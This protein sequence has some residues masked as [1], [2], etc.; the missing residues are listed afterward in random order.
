MK[1]QIGG[2]ARTHPTGIGFDAVPSKGF[3]HSGDARIHRG[4]RK[5]ASD[6]GDYFASPFNEVFGQQI[7]ACHIV[8]THEIEV[9]PA[10]IGEQV[11]VK[12]DNGYAGVTKRLGQLAVCFTLPGSQFHRGKEDAADFAR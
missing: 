1:F 3:T 11:A 10:R 4:G 2:V 9:T 7:T 6:K 12:L 8:N 5:R